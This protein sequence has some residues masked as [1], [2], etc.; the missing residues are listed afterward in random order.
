MEKLA[1]LSVI[2]VILLILYHVVVGAV[3]PLIQRRNGTHK[4][5]SMPG[6]IS[7]LWEWHKPDS[8]GTQSWKGKELERIL[9][10]I[11]VAIREQNDVRKETNALLNEVIIHLK[12][13]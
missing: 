10:D 7:D 13:S 11:G 3:I 5:N 4:N 6:K 12:E 2:A 1:E 9:L 8:T